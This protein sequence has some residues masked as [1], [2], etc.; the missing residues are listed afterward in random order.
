VK[1]LFL[2]P[3]VHTPGSDVNKTAWRGCE[4]AF[5]SEGAD[6]LDLGTAPWPR[7]RSGLRA[8]L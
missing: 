4:R 8:S 7:D 3:V 2:G 6:T 5:S 1:W